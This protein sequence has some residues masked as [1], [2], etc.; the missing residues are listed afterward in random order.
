MCFPKSLPSFPKLSEIEEL[1]KDA[2]LEHYWEQASAWCIEEGARFVDEIGENKDKFAEGLALKRFEKTRLEKAVAR[3]AAVKPASPV[4]V[5]PLALS[6][7]PFG[8]H[9]VRVRNTFLD[10]DYRQRIDLPR[11]STAPA[12]QEHRNSS[13]SEE[14]DVVQPGSPRGVADLAFYKTMTVVDYESLSAWGWVG[15]GGDIQGDPNLPC[16]D[17]RQAQSV[18]PGAAV[19]AVAVMPVVSVNPYIRWTYEPITGPAPIPDLAA[20][21]ERN[22]VIQRTFS[23]LSSV[24]RIRWTVDSRKLKSFDQVAASPVFELSFAGPVEFRMILKPRAVHDA[25]GGASFKK[26]LGWGS[27]G[28][29]CL[30]DVKDLI[31]PVVTF[32][33]GVGSHSNPKKQQRH[34]GPVRH[35]VR[36]RPICGLEGRD[37]WWD[38]K[39]SVDKQTRTFVVCLEV[40]PSSG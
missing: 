14:V 28:L 36:E 27:V 22:E 35:D 40:F 23:A 3:A 34:R 38:F 8:E 17:E 10:F 37:E 19:Y 12:G 29:K 25:G 31:N 2:G 1:L 7:Q 6:A 5:P 30:C 16:A 21:P 39:R 4:P 26:A 20:R 33:L 13:D 18:E 9:A 15:N 24:Y 11:S 32:R